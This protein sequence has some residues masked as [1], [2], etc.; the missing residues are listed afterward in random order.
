MYQS[1]LVPWNL[2]QLLQEKKEES[3]TRHDYKTAVL[4]AFNVLYQPSK[5]KKKRKRL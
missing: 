2:L 1:L 3:L 4:S 5:K